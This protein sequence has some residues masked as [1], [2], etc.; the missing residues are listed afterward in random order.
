MCVFEKGI[1]SDRISDIILH[2]IKEN[3]YK[4]SEFVFSVLR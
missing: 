1:G 2:N 4:Y 3:I